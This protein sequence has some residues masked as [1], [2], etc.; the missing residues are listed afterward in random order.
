MTVKLHWF[1]PTSGDSRTI[2]ERF[3]ANKSAGPAA[4]RQPDIDYL[5]QKYLGKEKYPFREPGEERITIVIE[6]E[7]ITG[8]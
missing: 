6:P 1:L 5:A 2:V 7:Q 8:I 4:A 3:H